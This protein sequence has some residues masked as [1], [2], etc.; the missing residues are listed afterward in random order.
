MAK[1]NSKDYSIKQY[2]GAGKTILL[3]VDTVKL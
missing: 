2:H 3:S 1:E